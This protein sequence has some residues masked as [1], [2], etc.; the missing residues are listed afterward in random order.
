MEKPN[1]SL[2]INED[3]NLTK[4]KKARQTQKE[5]VTSYLQQHLYQREDKFEGS[6][7]GKKGKKNY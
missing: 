2:T 4:M 7:P 3:E 5:K 6:S 1:T